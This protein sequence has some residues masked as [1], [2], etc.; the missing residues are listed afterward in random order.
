MTKK[1]AKEE[2]KPA[3]PLAGRLATPENIFSIPPG[4]LNPTTQVETTGPIPDPRN[5]T[6][7]FTSLLKK[8]VRD[9]TQTQRKTSSNF[10]RAI[11]LSVETTEAGTDLQG[12]TPTVLGDLMSMGRLNTSSPLKIVTIRALIP[13]LHQLRPI[14]AA[15]DDLETIKLYPT[16]TT[17]DNIAGN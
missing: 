14:P 1:S 9:A 13:E 2:N 6:S 7:T 11:V 5:I 12:S 10:Y 16:F 17:I 3:S 15:P 4:M 8:Q